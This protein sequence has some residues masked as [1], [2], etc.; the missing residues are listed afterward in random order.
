V[1]TPLGGEFISKQCRTYFEETGIDIIPPYMIASKETV[2]E[3][4]KPKFVKKPNLPEVRKSF[5]EHMVNVSQPFLSCI[6]IFTSLL[7]RCFDVVR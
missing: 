4:E 6:L 5:H 1:K 7:F 2:W 3:N